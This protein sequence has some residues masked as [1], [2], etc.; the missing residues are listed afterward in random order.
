VAVH[1]FSRA[2]C[3]VTV[4]LPDDTRDVI[5]VFGRDIGEPRPGKATLIDLDGYDYRW[6]RLR[7][8]GN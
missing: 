2:A 8:G 6:L 3:A 4:D 5:H 7:R 1:N